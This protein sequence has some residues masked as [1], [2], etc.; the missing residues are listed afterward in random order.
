MMRRVLLLLATV[1]IAG[2][3]DSRRFEVTG[4]LLK[5]EKSGELTVSHDAIP[6]YMDAMAMPFTLRRAEEA[7][8]IRPGDRI[9]FRLTVSETDSFIDHIRVVSAARR[10]AGLTRSPTERLL[11]QVGMP[12]PDFELLDQRGE[13]R[14]LHSFSGQ[15]VVLTFI[16]TRCPLPDYCPRMMLNFREI[17][18]R[19]HERVGNGV[20]LLTVTFDPRYDSSEVLARYARFHGVSGPGWHLLTGSPKEIQKVTEA[21]GIEFWPEEGLFTHTLQTAVIDRHGRLFGTL[22]GKDYSVQQLADL[23]QAA[24]VAP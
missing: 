5:Y 12:I 24:L 11:V 8:G 14:T 20:T 19:L 10:D 21:F 9:A 22:E 16:Y 1:A 15:V 18:Q 2:C 3:P 4:V 17:S 6:G 23:V 13:R 7:A